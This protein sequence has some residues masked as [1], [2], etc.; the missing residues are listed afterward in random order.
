M[1]RQTCIHPFETDTLARTRVTAPARSPAMQVGNAVLHALWH[2]WRGTRRAALGLA[3][4]RRVARER[5][6][7]AGLDARELADIGLDRETARREAGRGL[8]DLPPA[9]RR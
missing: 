6:A 1:A 2:G 3:L 4:A 5:R 7:L 9:R 8:L